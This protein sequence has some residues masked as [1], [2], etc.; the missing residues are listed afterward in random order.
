MLRQIYHYK[1]RGLD[2]MS[3]ISDPLEYLRVFVEVFWCPVLDVRLRGRLSQG[4]FWENP[5]AGARHHIPGISTGLKLGAGSEVLRLTGRRRRTEM[6]RGER[7]C[8]SSPCC[9]TSV[10]VAAELKVSLELRGS[11]LGL[12]LTCKYVN[13][14]KVIAAQQRDPLF[15]GALNEI[16]I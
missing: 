2:V 8:Q 3:V 15:L 16:L 4:E 10:H 5:T 14:H 13:I 12:I 11:W 1:W 9:T 6:E 7:R